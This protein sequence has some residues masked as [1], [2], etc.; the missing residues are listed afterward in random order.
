MGGQYYPATPPQPP[1][2]APMSKEDLKALEAAQ[3]RAYYFNSYWANLLAME[4]Q[5]REGRCERPLRP[6]AWKVKN[7][8]VRDKTGLECAWNK[9][10]IKS[11]RLT[12]SGHGSQPEKQPEG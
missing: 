12:W 1:V 6:A 2:Y 7:F 9:K 8:L 4:K 5:W 11:Q 10:K 3:M